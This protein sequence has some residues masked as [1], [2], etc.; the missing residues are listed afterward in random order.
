M[1]TITDEQKKDFLKSIAQATQNS[2]GESKVARIDTVLESL[3]I[4][5]HYGLSVACYDYIYGKAVKLDESVPLSYSM[6]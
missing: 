5:R 1:A 6:V 3:E 4:L 2:K